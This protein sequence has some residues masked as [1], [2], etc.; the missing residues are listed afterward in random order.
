M[1]SPDVWCAMRIVMDIALEAENIGRWA[2]PW[3]Y[4]TTGHMTQVLMSV[5]A[6]CIREHIYG[7]AKR[8]FAG[9]LG[10]I[11]TKIGSGAT[12]A[13]ALQVKGE[14]PLDEPWENLT[15]GSDTSLETIPLTGESIRDGSSGV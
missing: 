1:K 15:M 12:R 5:H 7:C 11:A 13:P 10:Y 3:G 4:G 2:E 6:V 9:A 8:P 14:W